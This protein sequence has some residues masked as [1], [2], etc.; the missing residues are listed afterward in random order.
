MI[1]L[2][3]GSTGV[4]GRNLLL[5]AMQDASWSHIILPVRS[6]EK[7]FR[8][9]EKE[10]IVFDADRLH[11]CD[12]EKNE[13]H[14]PSLKPDVVL[15]CA[16]LTFSRARENYFETNVEGTLNLFKK[17]PDTAR[18]F[19]LSSQAAGGPTPAK[20]EKRNR[21]HEDKPVSWYGASKLAMEKKLLELSAERVLILRPPMILGPRDTAT[22]PLFKMAQS[23]VRMKPGFA[24]KEYSWID[25]G[26]LCR[27]ILTAAKADWRI[28]PERLYFLSSNQ[29][30]TDRE[31]L[32][33][34]AM[35]VGTRGITL[36]LPHMAI[37]LLS[38]LVDKIPALHQPL[39]SLGRDRVKEILPRRWI[40][41]GSDFQRDFDWQP[42]TT[43]Q[44]S[45][46]EA[47]NWVK[48]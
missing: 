20:I 39:Q 17:L 42:T 18:F 10:K 27:A 32:K 44:E 28:L 30:I 4:V 38:M 31:L 13:W 11:L 43:L 25:V 12:V 46:Q 24:T 48:K 40:V 34:A 8:Q 1:L 14:L 3:T 9:L 47:A 15:H 45:L 41:D 7:F 6:R 36:P 16:G 5:Q 35:A 26:D 29:T 2:I 22:L 33:T 23:P 19:V 21:T 37:Q